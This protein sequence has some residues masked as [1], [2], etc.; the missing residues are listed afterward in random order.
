MKMK[1]DED[2]TQVYWDE[3]GYHVMKLPDGSVIIPAE[4]SKLRT[5]ESFKSFYY[6]TEDFS[7]E[8]SQSF[9]NVSDLF[10][11]LEILNSEVEKLKKENDE[12]RQRLDKIF[13]GPDII[14]IQ[15]LPD[16][17]IEKIIL[18]FL[19]KHGNEEIYPSD[20]AFAYDLDA[21]KVFE[22]CKKLKKEGK[23][24]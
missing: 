21:K 22:I 3:S 18:K 4:V 15:E 6:I 7:R 2:E 16:K 14:E 5:G 12:I 13:N 17:N 24:I 10:K 11:K 19:K 9:I 23:I 20:I 1:Q 8:T